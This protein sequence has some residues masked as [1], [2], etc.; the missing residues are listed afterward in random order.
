MN[1]AKIVCVILAVALIAICVA[2]TTRELAADRSE[3]YAASIYDKLTPALVEAYE[4]EIAGAPI[5][6]GKSQAYLQRSAQQLGVCVG[7]LKAII[8]LQD[9]VAKL[10]ENSSLSTLAAMND[11]EL[12][13]YAKNKATA[14]ANTLAPERRDQ[15]KAILLSALKA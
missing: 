3:A 12:L 15:L 1:R 8:L 7:K 13:F 6:S 10:G 2:G 11:L 5:V 14:Y 9:L 4:T